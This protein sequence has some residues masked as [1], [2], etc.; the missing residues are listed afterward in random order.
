MKETWMLFKSNPRL[1]SV[2]ILLSPAKAKYGLTAR[3]KPVLTHASCTCLGVSQLSGRAIRGRPA[4]VDGQGQ[5]TGRAA[6]AA[7]RVL[8]FSNSSLMAREDDLPS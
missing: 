7:G 1:P 3:T 5:G 8:N 6:L 2:P 4:P